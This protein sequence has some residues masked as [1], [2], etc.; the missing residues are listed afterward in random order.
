MSADA[1]SRSSAGAAIAR[2][3]GLGIFTALVLTAALVQIYGAGLYVFAGFHRFH[4]TFG[5]VLLL[6]MLI[7]GAWVVASSHRAALALPMGIALIAAIAA[8]FLVLYG[9]QLGGVLASI[10]PLFGVCL[11]IAEFELLMRT[12]GRRRRRSPAPS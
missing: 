12:W 4:P 10:H 3:G 11:V 2:P 9:P 5:Y 6:M 1:A 8:P 7:Q